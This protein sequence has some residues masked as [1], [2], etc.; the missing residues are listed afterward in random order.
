V[1]RHPASQHSWQPGVLDVA[2]EKGDKHTEGGMEVPAARICN[3]RLTHSSPSTL[4]RRRRI[5]P[6]RALLHL[7]REGDYSSS[8][9]A[10]W[11]GSDAVTSEAVGAR[12]STSSSRGPWRPSSPPHLK[13]L[14]SDATTS[15]PH[16]GAASFSWQCGLLLSRRSA[17]AARTGGGD[18]R[19]RPAARAGWRHGRCPCSRRRGGRGR[20]MRREREEG[21]RVGGERDG[22][23]TWERRWLAEERCIKE[24]DTPRMGVGRGETTKCRCRC[25]IC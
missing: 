21:R 11:R 6:P 2:R 3:V 5:Q 1:C 14:L 17:P 20:P 12:E 23:G 25:S 7:A 4:T 8:P 15:P 24:R 9:R 10:R 16:G 22:S 13:L 18:W 19:I